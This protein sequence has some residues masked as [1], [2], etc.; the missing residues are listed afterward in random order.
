MVTTGGP[1]ECS[2]RSRNVM[3]P[4]VQDKDKDKDKA[5]TKRKACPS[6]MSMAAILQGESSSAESM[7]AESGASACNAYAPTRGRRSP[8]AH[9]P[10][11]CPW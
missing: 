3:R 1:T 7:D 2:Y 8:E 4:S 11:L 5:R 10:A 6:E 9:A